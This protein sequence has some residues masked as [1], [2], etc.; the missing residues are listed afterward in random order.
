MRRER[1]RELVISVSMRQ[2]LNFVLRSMY[3]EFKNRNAAC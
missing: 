2:P 1:E 3:M